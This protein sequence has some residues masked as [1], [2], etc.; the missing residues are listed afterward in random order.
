MGPRTSSTSSCMRECDS[1]VGKFPAG[2][3]FPGAEDVPGC[4]DEDRSIKGRDVTTQE[5]YRGNQQERR[6]K[7]FIDAKGRSR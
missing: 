3:S 6:E 1:G 5:R 2:S 7:L 4:I